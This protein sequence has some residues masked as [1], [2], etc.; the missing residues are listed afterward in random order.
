[1]LGQSHFSQGE[2]EEAITCW[3]R[4]AESNPNWRQ[5]HSD[6][7]RTA[8]ILGRIEQ[9]LD[10]VEQGAEPPE[11]DEL[12]ADIC[13]LAVT[14][15][16]VS[17]ASKERALQLMKKTVERSSSPAPATLKILAAAYASCGRFAEAVSAVDQAIAK[18]SSNNKTLLAELV[19]HRQRYLAGQT[20]V[21]PD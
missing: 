15:P 19:D 14:D 16:R 17:R 20:I 21:Q 6:I 8:L 5:P 9:A 2:L 13:W 1:M 4:A 10:H 11:T 18:T 3:K 7:A 12:A